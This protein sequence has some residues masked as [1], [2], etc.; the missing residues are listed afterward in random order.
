MAPPPPPPIQ[1][2]AV[3]SGS[4]VGYIFTQGYYTF[5]VAAIAQTFLDQAPH[6][7][8]AAAVIRIFMPAISRRVRETKLITAALLLAGVALRGLLLGN[9]LPPTKDSR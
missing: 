9:A 6:D 8:Q 3:T 4:S 7:P 2:P 1:A 5:Q